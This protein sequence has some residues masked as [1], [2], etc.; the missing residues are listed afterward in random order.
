[1]DNS[2]SSN[3][4]FLYGGGYGN[5]S[6]DTK[7]LT[8]HHSG[9]KITGHDDN[10]RL[11]LNGADG[12]ELQYNGSLKIRVDSGAYRPMS[13]GGYDSGAGSYRWNNVFGITSNFSSDATLKKNM[14]V[15]DLG[16]DFI[17]SLNPIKYNWKVSFN[18]DGKTHYGFK[19]QDIEQ[20]GLADAVIGE[21]GEK[22]MNFNELFAP[23]VKCMQEMMDRIEALENA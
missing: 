14:V 9:G 1:M 6:Q 22:G 21:E 2:S 7:R 18:D 5:T 12:L 15:S 3:D 4:L 8:F 23:M 10:G 13:N 17:K 11:L 20:T 19:A 16:S